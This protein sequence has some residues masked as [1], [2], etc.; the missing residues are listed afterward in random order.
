MSYFS[1]TDDTDTSHCDDDDMILSETEDHDTHDHDE[2]Y[3]MHGQH[4]S[5][6]ITTSK[7]L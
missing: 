7:D 5:S 4:K 3:Y 6:T 1:T 2:V